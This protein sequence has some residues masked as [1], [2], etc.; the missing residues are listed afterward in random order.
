MHFNLT[1]TD[2]DA[3]KE[4]RDIMR[5]RLQMSR[6]MIKK[7]KLYGVLEV[8]GEHRRVIDTVSAGDKVFAS[9]G[10]EDEKLKHDP[11]VP[12]LFEDEYSAVV[13]KPDG[14]CA[15]KVDITLMEGVVE[16]GSNVID[17]INEP[18]IHV[19][20]VSR[21]TGQLKYLM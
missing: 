8:N 15:K 19:L 17:R 12:I 9:Y 11:S 5:D 14:R 2:E 20:D 21:L 6:T 7:V 18:N 13:F 10:E 4:L 1:V 16:P 3:G